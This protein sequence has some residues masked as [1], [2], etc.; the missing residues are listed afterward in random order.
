MGSCRLFA[1]QVVWKSIAKNHLSK[2]AGAME[3]RVFGCTGIPGEVVGLDRLVA[4]FVAV[5]ADDGAG[6]R[7]EGG[8]EQLYEGKGDAIKDLPAIVR[9]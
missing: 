7:C 5:G 6:F 8:A 1:C 2:V 4:A 9:S 3:V